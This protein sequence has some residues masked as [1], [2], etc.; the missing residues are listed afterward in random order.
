MQI[1]EN[2]S[3]H[4]ISY[5]LFI[6]AIELYSSSSNNRPLAYSTVYFL[7]PKGHGIL[8]LIKSMEAKPG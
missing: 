8:K 5:S 7:Q 3:G 6:I 1:L 2:K 4:F